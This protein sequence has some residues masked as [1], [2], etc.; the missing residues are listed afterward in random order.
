MAVPAPAKQLCC[1]FLETVNVLPRA[2]SWVAQRLELKLLPICSAD[3]K[4]SK[5]Q[6]WNDEREEFFVEFHGLAK[7]AF[8]FE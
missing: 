5:V 6:M 7:Y 8:V 2:T 1:V 3:F 4:D